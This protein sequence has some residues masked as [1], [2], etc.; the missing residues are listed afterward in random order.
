MGAELR[1]I[2]SCCKLNSYM[3]YGQ[4]CPKYIV[5]QILHLRYGY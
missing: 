1:K 2:K 3:G 5:N 4:K